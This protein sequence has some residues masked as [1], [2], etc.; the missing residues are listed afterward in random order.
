[1]EQDIRWHQRLSNYRKALDRFNNNISYIKESV[2]DLDIE[3]QNTLQE[4]VIEID[5]ILKQGLIQSFEFTHEL[6]WKTMKDYA[7]YQGNTEISGSRDAIRYFAS[8]HLIEQAE[9]W[10]DMIVSRNKTSHTYNEDTANEIFINII[11]FYAPLF[12]IFYSKLI[13]IR[14]GQSGELFE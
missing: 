14:D 10:M 13:T 2:K 7:E 5:D 11:L 6:A 1:M 8:V 12:E 4:I 3:D 9:I